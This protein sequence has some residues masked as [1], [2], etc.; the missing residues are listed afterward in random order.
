MYSTKIEIPDYPSGLPE[1]IRLEVA[2]APDDP[3][4]A[5]QLIFEGKGQA[6]FE[7]SGHCFEIRTSEPRDVIGD[8]VLV[9]SA[10]RVGERLIRQNSAHNTLLVTERCDQI[11][12][13]CSQPPKDYE[14]DLFDTYQAALFYAPEGAVIGLSG[15]EPLLYKERVFELIS[16]THRE[17][18]DLGFHILTNGQNILASDLA[19]LHALPLHQISFAVPLYAVTAALHD[20]IVGKTGAFVQALDGI[21]TLLEAGAQVEIR[22]VLMRPN[23]EEL[24]DLASFLA[25]TMP[26][27]SH[28]AVMQMEY[29]GYARKNWSGLFFDHSMDAASLLRALDI[30]AQHG[31]RTLLYNMPLCTLPEHLRTLAPP[32]ISDWK[33]KF[34]PVCDGCQAQEACS[35]FFGWQRADQTYRNFGPTTP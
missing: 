23:A 28:W 35:G 5:A 21:A 20:E 3:V 32:T 9:N 11:C 22:T 4:P 13:M 19:A 14:L 18:P 30:T 17:R 34:M 12:V 2:G 27:I 29:I 16:R 15:G 31:V 6:W 24:P 33:R 25:W 26:D 10:R 7:L 8:V 1:L